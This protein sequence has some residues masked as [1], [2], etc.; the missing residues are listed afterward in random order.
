[1]TETDDTKRIKALEEQVEDLHADI[2]RLMMILRADIVE[3]VAVAL[4][5]IQALIRVLP[6]NVPS[7]LTPYG[8][9]NR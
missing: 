8:L 7:S 3:G 2:G 1:M 9:R 5:D 6:D 4:D